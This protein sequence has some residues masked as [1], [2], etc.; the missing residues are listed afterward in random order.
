MK[1]LS[2]REEANLKSSDYEAYQKYYYYL[3]NA[4]EKSKMNNLSLSTRKKLHPFLLAVIKLRNR[5]NGYHHTVIGDEREETNRPKIF[6]ITH[7][8]KA[9]IEVVSEALKE[10]YYLL[11][12]DFE[13]AHDTVDGLFLGLNGV[14]YFNEKN[15]EDRHNVKKRMVATLKMGGN[16]MYFPE[17]TWNLTASLPINQ[18][19][20]GIIDVAIEANA[21]IIPVAIEQYDKNFIS[22]VGKNFDVLNYGKERKGEALSELRDRMATLK[23]EIWS[24]VPSLT[25]KN[26]P[27]GYYERFIN[28]KIGEWSLTLEDFIEAIYKNAQITPPDEV[29]KPI[30][31]LEYKKETAF[32]WGS[33]SDYK[34]NR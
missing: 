14:I 13:S 27:D 16:I 17:G 1:K 6:A 29:F 9:D 23:W 24:S 28:E 22:K 21:I 34:G 31:E 11:C 25:R 7:I 30:R 33:I 4:Y 26:I 20:M 3:R 5:F 18:F 19:Y 2:R 15:K 8:G 10:H 32:L 12:G